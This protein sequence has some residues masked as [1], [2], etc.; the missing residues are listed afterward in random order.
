MILLV[1]YDLKG[2]STE[3]TQL[4]EY[5]KSHD[6]WSHYLAST[7]LIDTEKTPDE[8]IDGIR[9]FFQKG[10]RALVVRFDRPYQGWLPDK[11]WD[12]IHKHKE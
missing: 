9:P 3:Y 11:A 1:T 2:P 5:L 8:I 7:W 6:G 4:Y 12:W 10:D